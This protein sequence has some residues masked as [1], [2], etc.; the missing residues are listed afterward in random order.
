[1]DPNRSPEW[2]ENFFRPSEVQNQPTH[3]DILKTLKDLTEKTDAK[4]QRNLKKKEKWLKEVESWR[5]CVR[6]HPNYAQNHP[7]EL[8]YEKMLKKVDKIIQKARKNRQKYKS[9]LDSLQKNNSAR[10]FV[11]SIF[12][13]NENLHEIWPT[14]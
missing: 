3:F 2:F 9:K 7:E 4:L 14:N 11:S 6:H 8:K 12:S 5:N 10:W 13:P 1:M